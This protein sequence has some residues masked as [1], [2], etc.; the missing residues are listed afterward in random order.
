MVGREK[1]EEKNNARLHSLKIS[2]TR[3]ADIYTSINVNSCALFTYDNITYICTYICG[4]FAHRSENA[5]APF[6]CQNI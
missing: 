5:H 3:I 6:L 4:I 2:F 1:N